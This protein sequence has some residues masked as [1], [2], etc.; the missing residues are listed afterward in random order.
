[1]TKD[2]LGEDILPSTDVDYT[3]LDGEGRNAGNKRITLGEAEY[4]ED[5]VKVDVRTRVGE[6]E[7]HDN[8]YGPHNNM[9]HEMNIDNGEQDFTTGPPGKENDL[10]NKHLDKPENRDKKSI[11]E[12]ESEQGWDLFGDK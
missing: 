2:E 3:G 6:T 1:M 5:G 7:K 11:T 10:Q 8:G 4:E 12:R 9:Q